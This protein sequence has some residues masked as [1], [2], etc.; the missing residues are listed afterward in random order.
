MFVSQRNSMTVKISNWY[1]QTPFYE[2]PENLLFYY[3]KAM[4]F[5]LWTVFLSHL[6]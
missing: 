4:A 5:W 2:M 1:E 6:M 3:K